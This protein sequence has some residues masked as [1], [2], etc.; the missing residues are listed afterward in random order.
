MT[1]LTEQTGPFIFAHRGASAHAPENTLAA[2]ELAV[3]SG[4]HGIELDVKLSAD[5]KVIVLHD[6]TV[7]RTTDGFG[8][9][10]TLLSS[11]LRELNASVNFGSQYPLQHVPQ[12]DEVFELVGQRTYFNI[13]LTNLSTPR[14][15][16]PER[17]AETI[18]HH[19]LQDRVLISSFLHLNLKRIKELL[20]EVPVAILAFQGITGAAA[21]STFGRRRSPLIIHPHHSDVDKRF[22]KR[23]KAAG[24]RV[25]PW[26]VNERAEM[27]RLFKLGVDGLFTDD[28]ALA[29]MIAGQLSMN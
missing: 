3:E 18:V 22:M 14:D 2:F 19:G 6:Q 7:D 16:L 15:E 11:T 5:E 17:V 28:P 25:H 1:F 23:E 26:V 27:R 4:A 12:L 24:R 9:V 20:P 10:R 29:R 21:R 13:E 8:D